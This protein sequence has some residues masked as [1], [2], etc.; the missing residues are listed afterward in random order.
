MLVG[1]TMWHQWARLQHSSLWARLLAHHSWGGHSGII[2]GTEY[3]RLFHWI[4][5]CALHKQGNSPSCGREGLEPRQGPFRICL[6]TEADKSVLEAEMVWGSLWIFIGAVLSQDRSWERAES[7][8]QD[9]FW[10]HWWDPC[11]WA[12]TETYCVWF[13]LYPFTDDFGSRLKAKLGYSQ[14]LWGTAISESES[15]SRVS[16]SDINYTVSFSLSKSFSDFHC[17]KR[18]YKVS[19]V[20]CESIWLLSLRVYFVSLTLVL[21]YYF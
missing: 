3:T 5:C 19:G 7:L 20:V 17:C 9:S 8:L 21:L 2:G 4:S 10:V 1:S 14:I 15:R 13:S 16:V 11:W 18:K 12:D 6:R